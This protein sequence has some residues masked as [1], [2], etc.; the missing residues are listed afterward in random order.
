M[1]V[2]KK[3]QETTNSKN[4]GEVRVRMRTQTYIWPFY[5]SQG[6]QQIH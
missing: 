1:F 4:D 2:H 6:F 3:N 5:K